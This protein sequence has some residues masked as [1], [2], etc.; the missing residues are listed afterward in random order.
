MLVTFQTHAAAA[1]AQF[2]YE[3]RIYIYIYFLLLLYLTGAVR[4]EN[5]VSQNVQKKTLEVAERAET[6]KCISIIY[7]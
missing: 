1:Q 6:S 2:I 3:I 5:I 7:F 4:S